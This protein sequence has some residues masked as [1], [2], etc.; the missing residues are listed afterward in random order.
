M[1]EGYTFLGWYRDV[2][3]NCPWTFDADAVTQDIT[4]YA[5][6]RVHTEEPL[7]TPSDDPAPPVLPTPAP[8]IPQTGETGARAWPWLLGALL[9]IAAAW[10]IGPAAYRR[11]QMNH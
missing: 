6:W 8:D 10:R 1:R 4:L 9:S 5:R 3:W 7:P 11:K 2:E